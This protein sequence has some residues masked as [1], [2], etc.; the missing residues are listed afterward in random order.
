MSL[1]S[2]QTNN[3]AKLSDDDLDKEI[4][5]AEWPDSIPSD[6]PAADLWAALLRAEKA[7]RAIRNA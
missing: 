7:E 1:R 2:I 3:I 5:F 4:A 6:D